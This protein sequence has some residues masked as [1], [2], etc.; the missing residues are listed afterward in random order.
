MARRWHC[1]FCGLDV[2]GPDL[3]QHLI[4]HERAAVRQIG[5]HFLWFDEDHGC[6]AWCGAGV[7][8]TARGMRHAETCHRR[9]T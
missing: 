8:R 7:P 9:A 4:D 1:A 3:Q 5:G 2:V 6:C